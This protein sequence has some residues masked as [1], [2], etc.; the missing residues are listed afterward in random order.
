MNQFTGQMSLLQTIAEGKVG[1]RQQQILDCLHEQ[2][3]NNNEMAKRLNLPINS[4]TP[5]V[6]ELVKKGLVAE[7]KKAKDHLTNRLVIYWRKL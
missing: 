6:R 4:I 2:A 1:K 7:H 5:R 3:L